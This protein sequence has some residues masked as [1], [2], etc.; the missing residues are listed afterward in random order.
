M[1][2]PAN[3]WVVSDTMADYG[4]CTFAL[5][6]IHTIKC[7]LVW[8]CYWLLP[9]WRFMCFVT[10]PFFRGGY[11]AKVLK[12]SFFMICAICNIIIQIDC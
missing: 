10:S 6:D 11:L 12:G 9:C 8:F 4:N 7:L 1:S 3:G 5:N 2:A